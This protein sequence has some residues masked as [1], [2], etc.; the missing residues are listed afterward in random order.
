MA[1]TFASSSSWRLKACGAAALGMAVLLQPSPGV[2]AGTPATGQLEGKVTVKKKGKALK[3]S[4]NVVIYLEDV[5]GPVPEGVTTEAEIKQLDKKF[6]PEIN[7]VMKG[8]SIA[9]P[10]EDDFF[11]N[12]FSVSRPAR[13]DLGLY[14]AGESRSVKFKRPGVVDIYCNIHPD[15]A[16]KVLVVDTGWFTQSDAAG[17]F[18]LDGIPAGTYPYV[19]WYANGDEVT[20]EVTIPANGSAHLDIEVKHKSSADYHLR[21]DGTPYGRYK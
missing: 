19:A 15:M 9:F 21:K 1:K 17:N 2:T 20:G 10:N 13:F 12:V 4:A 11:H 8:N 18:K 6:L 16:A 5:P 7:V 3:S 14:R